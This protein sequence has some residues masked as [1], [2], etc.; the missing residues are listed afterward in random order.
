MVWNHAHLHRR[1]AEGLADRLEGDAVVDDRL[2]R[3]RGERRVLVPPRHE[4]AV[5]LVRENQNPALETDLP[6]PHE[7]LLR[8]AVPRGVLGIAQDEHVGVARNPGLQIIEVEPVDAVLDDE[9]A[10]FGDRL[11]PPQVEVEAVVGRSRQQ[12]LAAGPRHRLERGDERR[13]DA[14][15]ERHE[16][17]VDLEAVPLPVPVHDRREEVLRHVEV[18]PVLV[19]DPLHEGLGDDRGAFEVHVGDAHRHLDVLGAV[20]L[21]DAVPLVGVGPDP[22]VGLVEVEAARAALPRGR[23][24]RRGIPERASRGRRAGG[25]RRARALQEGS[26]VQHGSS[27][28]G[29]DSS[30]AIV[31]AVSAV[32]CADPGTARRPSA[33]ADRPL[34]A[35]C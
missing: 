33:R 25:G 23:Q 22:L 28:H 35:G 18:A 11:R 16:V 21:D 26:P 10:L 19:P 12:H 3:Q 32:G 6:E 34:Y 27:G 2:V 15:G 24:R 9:R 29:V 13:V 8:P 4:I 5:D 30:F 31:P 7:V 1:Q 20:L 14:V 17:G